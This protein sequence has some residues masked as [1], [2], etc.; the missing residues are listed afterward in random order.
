[1]FGV[2]QHLKVVLCK[3][4]EEAQQKGHIYHEGFTAVEIDTVVVVQQGTESGNPTVDLVL[5][6]AAGNKY[7]V[8]VTGNLLKSIPLNFGVDDGQEVH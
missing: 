5:K 2:M 3:D 4:A 1:M 6:D 8:M 7:V